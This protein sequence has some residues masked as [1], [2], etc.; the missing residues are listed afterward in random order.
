MSRIYCN[1]EEK[2]LEAL[3][4]G[5]WDPELRR[6]A[7]TCAV[8]ADLV[9]AAEFLQYEAAP[10]EAEPTLPDA[11][12][13]FWKAQLAA[14][15]AAVARATRPIALVETLACLAGV[16]IALWF[17]LDPGPALVS[18]LSQQPLWSGPAGIAV[19]VCGAAA[20]VSVFLGSLYMVLTDK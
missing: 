13:I 9:L 10:A 12:L 19:L 1:Q 6:H 16:F 7:D 18:Q 11:G 14:R 2:V 4:S 17:F 20:L 8:C 5:A 3:R 15:R